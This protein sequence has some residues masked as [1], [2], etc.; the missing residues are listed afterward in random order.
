VREWI[1]HFDCRVATLTN[2]LLHFIS[3]SLSIFRLYLSASLSTHTFS[4]YIS[5]Y[6]AVVLLLLSSFFVCLLACVGYRRL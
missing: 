1:F 4:L 5:M 3:I 2:H 6:R